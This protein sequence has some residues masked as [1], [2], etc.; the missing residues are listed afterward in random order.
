MVMLSL[1]KLLCYKYTGQQ[2]IVIGAPVMERSD[3]ALSGRAGLYL[4]VLALRT[5]FDAAGSF[6]NLLNKVRTATLE[7]FRHKYY[8]LRQSGGR[9]G[10]FGRGQPFPLFETGFY[11]GSTDDPG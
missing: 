6:T 1:V 7:G 3:T 9:P 10:A 2:D 8:S 11:S 5:R 4:D